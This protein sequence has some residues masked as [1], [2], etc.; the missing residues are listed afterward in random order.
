MSI[1]SRAVVVSDKRVF[2]VFLTFLSLERGSMLRHRS[3]CSCSYLR[4]HS[5]CCCAAGRGGEEDSSPA[6]R[7]ENE[8]HVDVFLL[9]NSKLAHLIYGN[10]TQTARR[11]RGRHLHILQLFIHLEATLTQILD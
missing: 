6:A 11:K 7:H 2:V 1:N 9:Q 8:C 3:Y 10:W 4:P 5:F